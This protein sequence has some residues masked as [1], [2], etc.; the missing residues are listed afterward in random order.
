M[1]IT[2]Q[3]VVIIDY[4]AGNVFSVRNA[5]KHLGV[6]SIVSDLAEDILQADKIIFPG[7]GSAQAAMEALEQKKLLSIFEEISQPFLGVCLGMQLMGT[8]S[9]EGNQPCLNIIPYNIEVF[10]D[11]GDLE[12]PH[13]G[14]NRVSQN[15]SA[16]W[17]DIPDEEYF[18]FVHSYH[19][20]SSEFGIGNTLY[21]KSFCAA[22]QKDNFFGVQ[23]HP[24][25]SGKMGLRLLEN[26]IKI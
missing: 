5:L 22:V 19:L 6:N 9:E 18:Y 20:S 25:K 17:Q 10:S 21:G 14:W 1:S 12:I 15:S 13:M 16:I 23:F 24:E 11:M 26:F 7:V 2:N 4:G 3:K 8:F